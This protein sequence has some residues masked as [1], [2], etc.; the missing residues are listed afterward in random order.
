MSAEMAVA[1]VLPEAAFGVGLVPAEF[2]AISVVIIRN[3]GAMI[4]YLPHSSQVK[5]NRALSSPPLAGA[6]LPP[7]GVFYGYV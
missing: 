7:E 2:W 1:K 3:C 5:Q 4:F 6:D